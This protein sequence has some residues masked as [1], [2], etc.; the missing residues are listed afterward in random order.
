MPHMRTTIEALWTAG[1]KGKVKTMIGG[2]CVTQE[3][4]D[5]IGADG[6]SENAGAAVKKVKELIGL[7]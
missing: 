2:A 1:L 6:Y 4:A 5:E 7:N 3:Y